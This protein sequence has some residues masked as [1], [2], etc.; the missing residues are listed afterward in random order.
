MF[1]YLLVCVY[2]CVFVY[3][4]VHAP[5][6]KNGGHTAESSSLLPLLGFSIEIQVDRF[7]KRLYPLSH[8]SGTCI[9]VLSFSY[10]PVLSWHM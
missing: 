7:D 3:V 5:R 8:L 1:I 6:P 4:C 10:F 2:V 9:Q